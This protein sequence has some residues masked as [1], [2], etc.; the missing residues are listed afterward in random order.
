[1]TKWILPKPSVP[2]TRGCSIAC[3]VGSEPALDAQNGQQRTGG[4]RHEEDLKFLCRGR[5]DGGSGVPRQRSGFIGPPSGIRRFAKPSGRSAARKRTCSRLPT[6]SEDTGRRRS[7]LRTKPF[8][9]WRSACK[10]YD[11]EQLT[12]FMLSA[13]R[14]LR[15]PERCAQLSVLSTNPADSVTAAHLHH[16]TGPSRDYRAPP[17]TPHPHQPLRLRARAP[18]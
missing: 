17:G 8:T 12:L 15:S 7:G 3:P 6:T 16:Q 11:R 13:P 10:Q 18:G 1:M 5:C 4:H 14:S 2:D 9:S